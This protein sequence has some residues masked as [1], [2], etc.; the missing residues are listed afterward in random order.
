M[1]VELLHTDDGGEITATNGI[2][3]LNDGLETCVYLSL[4]GGAEDD[5]GG[6]ATKSRQWWGNLLE[7]DPARKYRSETQYLLRALPLVPA[8]LRRLELAAGRDLAWLVTEGLATEVEAVASMP[9]LNKVQIE[10]TLKSN[11]GDKKYGFLFA[12]RL[13]QAS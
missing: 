6:S 5:G 12:S 10:V 3:K 13:G 1:D 9:A 8:N 4:F 7:N 11:L 2:V